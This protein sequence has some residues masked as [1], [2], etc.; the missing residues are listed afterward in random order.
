MEI[1]LISAENPRW[2][3]VGHTVIVATCTFSH[4][5]EAVECSARANETDAHLQDFWNRTL[6]GEFGEIQE[7]VSE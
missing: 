7:F 2:G 6:S 5:S 3:N 1:E 4:L